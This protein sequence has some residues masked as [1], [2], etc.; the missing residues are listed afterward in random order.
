MSLNTNLSEEITLEFVMLS[1]SVTVEVCEFRGNSQTLLL[2]ILPPKILP[3][4]SSYPGI[5][6]F[7]KHFKADLTLKSNVYLSLL[8]TTF[9]KSSSRFSPSKTTV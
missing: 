6:V 4:S 9:L 7:P 2:P 3:T 1:Q 5:V 8:G